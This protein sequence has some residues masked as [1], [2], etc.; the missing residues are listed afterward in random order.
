[1]LS[2]DDNTMGVIGASVPPVII[3]SA[4]PSEISSADMP[5]ASTPAVH[6]VEIVEQNPYI[7]FLRATS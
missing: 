7:P 5:I 3:T 2:K 1:M 4:M 6:P